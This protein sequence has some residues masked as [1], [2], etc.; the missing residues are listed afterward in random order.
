MADHGNTGL[1]ARP[2]ARGPN[3][4]LPVIVA[5]LTMAAVVLAGLIVVKRATRPPTVLGGTAGPVRG[6]T[7]ATAS[8]GSPVPPTAV[9]I[10]LAPALNDNPHA[11]EV[12][13]LFRSYFDAI[14][15]R[16]YELWVST[17]SESRGRNETEAKFHNDYST[18]VDDQVHIVDIS[19]DGDG[20]L[21]RVS[22][23]SRQDPSKA[24]SEAPLPCL[25]WQF[26]YPLGREGGDLKISQV[27]AANRSFRACPTS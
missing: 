7:V 3:R 4:V 25:L 19:E 14:N 27:P 11:D 12:V 9:P 15:N 18:T 20:L 21:V 6:T 5:L 2:A 8:T 1:V 17:L 22:F 13:A 23:R 26:N 10:A 16:D 24:P